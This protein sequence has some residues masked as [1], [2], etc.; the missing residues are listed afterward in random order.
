MML[1]RR[2]D[3]ETLHA[4]D[5]AHALGNVH[6]A[7]HVIYGVEYELQ[8]VAYHA[9]LG[10]VGLAPHAPHHASA[11]RAHVVTLDLYRH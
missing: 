5:F 2:P 6:H 1:R 4:A 9:R 7:P 11:E 8:R 10:D 3:A